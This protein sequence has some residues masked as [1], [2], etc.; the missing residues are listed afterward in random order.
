M[1]KII[2]AFVL[3]LPLAG[4]AQSTE[5]G[6]NQTEAINQMGEDEISRIEQQ[7]GLNESRNGHIDAGLG[8]LGDMFNAATSARDMYDASTNFSQN[9]CT[10]DLSVS[11]QAMVPSSCA[12]GGACSE[13]FLSAANELNFVRRQLARLSCIYSNTKTFNDAALAFGD[14]VSGIHA[15]T[16]LAWQTQ[17]GDIVATFNHFKQTYDSKYTGLIG[18]LQRSLMAINDCEARFGMADWYQKFGFIY[19]EFMSDKYKRVD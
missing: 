11:N 7:N 8:A 15:V 3:I 4:M 6:D 14:N 1:K 13:C 12:D 18:S 17:R 16:G 5:Y 9:E 2:I 19:F 10:P